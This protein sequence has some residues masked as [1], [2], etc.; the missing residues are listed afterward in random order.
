MPVFEQ[1]REAGHD[2]VRRHVAPDIPVVDGSNCDETTPLIV[3]QVLLK[4]DA[5]ID[6]RSPVSTESDEDA[7]EPSSISVSPYCFWRLPTI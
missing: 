6:T 4:D 3:P 1:Q 5:A 7:R 2:H